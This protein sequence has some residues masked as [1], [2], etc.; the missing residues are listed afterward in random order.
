M[1]AEMGF[2]LAT[3]AGDFWA[4]WGACVQLEVRR[5]AVHNACESHVP[6]D[7]HESVCCPG[8]AST[9]SLLRS[10]LSPADFIY[11]VTDEQEVGSEMKR[12]LEFKYV[13]GGCDFQI[14][15]VRRH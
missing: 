9:G 14:T 15:V 4:V 10:L 11:V 3:R 5:L 7:V 1:S 12:L 6:R 13:L 2:I 8:D